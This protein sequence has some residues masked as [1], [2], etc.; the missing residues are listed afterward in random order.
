MNNIIDWVGL[1]FHTRT[2]RYKTKK[3]SEKIK[4]TYINYIII[5]KLCIK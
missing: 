1:S 4:D 3:E 2:L 5:K